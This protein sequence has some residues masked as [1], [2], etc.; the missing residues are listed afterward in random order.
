MARYQNIGVFL[1]AREGLDTTYIHATREVGEWIGTSGRTLVYGGSA[2]GL[3]EVLAEAVK[4]TGGNVVG[5][6][7]R[8]IT[9]RGLESKYMNRAIPC[10]DL[11]ER[12]ALL[13]RESDILL[14]LPGGIGTLDELFTVLG[15]VAI[16]LPT[17][18][19][20]VLYNACGIW[21]GLIGVLD[22]LHRQGFLRH[23]YRD[24][25]FVVNNIAE[26]QALL[27]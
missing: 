12:K 20:L 17:A 27:S 3:M 25:L 23:N 26:L 6:V 14:A 18:K 16:G 9:E 24:H 1:S 11:A 19:S 5:I 21:N 22:E 2:C 15:E 10:H 7:P 13:T 4:R 8:I